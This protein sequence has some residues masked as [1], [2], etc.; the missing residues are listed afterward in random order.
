M[1]QERNGKLLV[2]MLSFTLTY[3]LASVPHLILNVLTAVAD[4]SFL[5]EI[6]ALG[7]CVQFRT[8]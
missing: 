1:A 4:V 3:L 5:A 7:P 6:L 8:D 2:Q